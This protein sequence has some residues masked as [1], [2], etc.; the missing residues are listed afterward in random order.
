MSD[1]RFK[2]ISDFSKV[3]R[4]ASPRPIDDPRYFGGDVGWVR[5]ADVTASKKYLKRT[6]QYVSELGEK[7]SVRV[8]KGDLIMSIC[9][10]IGRPVIID[11]PACIHDGFVQLY[12]IKDSDTEFLY[13]SLQFSEEALKSQGQSGTQTNLNT[14]IVSDLE[15]FHPSYEEQ[16]RI[17]DVLSHI[18]QAIEQ[19]DAVIV[20]QQ[21]IK[22]GLMQDLLT[23]GVDD[24]GNIRSEESHE[25]K[26]SPLGRIP[27][28]WGWAPLKNYYA[29]TSRNGL[30]KPQQNYGSGSP[31]I[32]MPQMFRGLEVE[33]SDAVRVSVTPKELK[34]FGLEEGDILFARRSL[35]LEGAGQCSLV[36]KLREPTTFESSIIRVRL[37]KDE[38]R[39]A[40]VN[41]FLNTD[42]GYRLRLPLIRQVAVSGVS[43]EDIATIPVPCPLIDEQDIILS[44][45]EACDLNIEREFRQRKKLV[46]LKVGLMQDLLS[47]I[48][49][50]ETLLEFG[51]RTVQA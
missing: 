37:R 3:R 10:T 24:H 31:M 23:K 6:T 47:G 14:S 28:E 21:R 12:D 35:T 36:K 11:I 34:R 26:D 42:V 46:N 20:K 13:Y 4:G 38:I 8:D 39:P 1:K 48:K 50:V 9:G 43:S 19:A 49:S 15:I 51:H 32:H 45:V 22:A 33:D 44:R 18:D 25:F 30:Y 27:K 2:K 5:I 16:T 7:N 17:A 40:F 29:C 41:Q